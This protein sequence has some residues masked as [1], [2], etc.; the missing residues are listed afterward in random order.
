MLQTINAASVTA[1]AQNDLQA[2]TC[3]LEASQVQGFRSDFERHALEQ[4]PREACGVVA[5]GQYWRCRNIADNPEQDFV[6]DP[7]DYAVAALYGRIEAIVHSHPM[8]GGASKTD[9]R[10]CRGLGL[11][12][13]IWSMPDNVW[14]TI[15]P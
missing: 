12:W 3:H 14:T 2:A 8:G 11:P 5:D 1:A 10:S 4:A 6:I 9:I 15:K 13:H 7:R